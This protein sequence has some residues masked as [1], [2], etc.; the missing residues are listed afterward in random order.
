MSVPGPIA[1][2][3]GG[4]LAMGVSAAAGTGIGIEVGYANIVVAAQGSWVAH[5][6]VQPTTC[7]MKMIRW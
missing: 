4:N 2:G 5:N 7:T 1:G 6:N 3:Q